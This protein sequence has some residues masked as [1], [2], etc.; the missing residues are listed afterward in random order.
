MAKHVLTKEEVNESSIFEHAA[1]DA[2]SHVQREGVCNYLNGFTINSRQV[3]KDFSG[4][5]HQWVGGLSPRAGLTGSA[6]EDA[7]GEEANWKYGDGHD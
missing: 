7:A 3:Q 1:V 6:A 5:L 2:P 4:L